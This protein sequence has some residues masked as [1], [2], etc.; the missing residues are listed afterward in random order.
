MGYNSKPIKFK[1]GKKEKKSKTLLDSYL[2][3]C[4]YMKFSSN[5]R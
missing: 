5:Q 1:G 4:E 2:S 3:K